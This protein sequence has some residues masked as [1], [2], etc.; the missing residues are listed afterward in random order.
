[1]RQLLLNLALIGLLIMS[2]VPASAQVGQ[3]WGW[4]FNGNGQLGLGTQIDR[5]TPVQ[6][7]NFVDIVQVAGGARHSAL[8][9][10]DGTVWCAGWNGL[11]Q[12]GDGTGISREVFAPV[13]G[14]SG[15]VQ[16][17]VG[18]NHNLALKADGTVW[19]WGYNGHGALGI[20]TTEHQFAPVPIAG[21]T[22]VAQVSAGAMHSFALKADG[23]V[24][25]WGY[26]E[27]GQIGDGST[28]DRTNPSR[29]YD[30]ADVV[31]ISAGLSHSL[32]LKADGTVWAWGNNSFG[33]LGD[34]TGEKIYY[35]I[36]LPDL[37]SIVQVAAGAYHSFAVKADGTLWAWGDNEYG[38]LGDSTFVKRYAPVPVTGITGALQVVG[39]AYHS[40]ALRSDGTVWAW[41]WNYYGQLGDGT[42]TDRS[43]PQ[44]VLGLS[45]QSIIATTYAHCFSVQGVNTSGKMTTLKAGNVSATF[46]KSFT[47]SA[48]LT[49]ASNTALTSQTVF[50]SVDG[51][52]VGSAVTNA[53]GT[54]SLLISNSVSIGAGEH[55]LNAFFGGDATYAYSWAQAKLTTLEAPTKIKVG[56]L[57]L[58][59]G[60]TKHLTATLTRTTDNTP[61]AGETLIFRI[62]TNV[63]GT[64]VTD[65]TGN[66]TL[67]LTGDESL[68]AGK[69]PLFVE[70]DG[71]DNHYVYL[72]KA[73]LTIAQSPTKTSGYGVA[74]KAGASVTLKAMLTR[75]TDKRGLVNRAITYLIDGN[76]VGTA[77]TDGTGKASLNYTIPSGF[78][79]GST[80]AIVLQF[81]G[82][83]LY[84]SS[85]GGAILTVK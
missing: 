27:Y 67:S 50:F 81:V 71:D 62:F 29:I 75:T 73:N 69:H 64:A 23:T 33:Q 41:G 80:H 12:L 39:G 3:P 36:K 61:L 20:G 77:T 66:A 38:Q 5:S 35:P 56:N 21:L 9:R 82:D 68:S 13:A 16:I 42:N 8:L 32:A 59:P 49:D 51:T 58:M 54:A 31:R 72:A 40:L 25:G 43:T 30:F 60:Q 45:H 79:T 53:S 7:P 76:A 65:S 52:T 83:P 6:I 78:A 14:L 84:I 48:T 57:T 74:G 19:V 85:S 1:M 37:R 17:A 28:L 47:L 15:V 63:L 34:G 2:L 44:Q 10:A 26:N 55:T 24:W 4:G 70:F 22:N 46:S 18:W 11:G